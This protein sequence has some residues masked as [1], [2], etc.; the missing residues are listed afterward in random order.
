MA[1]MASSATDA[2]G[3]DVEPETRNG[4]LPGPHLVK[5]D[6][7]RKRLMSEEPFEYIKRFQVRCCNLDAQEIR[8]A[9]D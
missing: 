6:M 5:A 3:T 4:S 1:T 7:I 9:T 2:S 8:Y